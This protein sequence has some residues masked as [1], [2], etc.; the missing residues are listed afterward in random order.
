MMTNDLRI[1]GALIVSEGSNAGLPVQYDINHDG[2]ADGSLQSDA[3][4]HFLFD[5]KTPGLM[6]GAYTVSVRGGGYEGGSMNISYGEWSDLTFSYIMPTMPSVVG[7][8]LVNDTGTPGDLITGD[9]LISGGLSLSDGSS[10][11][12]PLTYD[13]NGDGIA[14]GSTTTDA[15]GHFSFDP[16]GANLSYGT[17]TISVRG[18][19]YGVDP[20]NP[21]AVN[22]GAGADLTLTYMPPNPETDGPQVSN[23]HVVQDSGMPGGMF[24][25]GSG[26]GPRVGGTVTQAGAP[27]MSVSVQYD[28]N[29]DGLPEGYGYTNML[30]EFTIDLTNQVTSSSD[31]TVRVRAADS[32]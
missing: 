17:R 13:L 12:L 4:G 9:P 19:R 7:L 29:G 10:A 27:A 20:L 28:L 1:S 5:F 26:M 31:V 18:G 25:G 11:Y 8:A 16:R 21:M 30:G 15:M 14:D 24:P 2:I 3:M 22:Y 6:Y 23:L 32:G